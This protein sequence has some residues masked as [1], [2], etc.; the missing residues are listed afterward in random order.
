VCAYL[1]ADLRDPDTILADAAKTLDFSQPVAV[2]LLAVMHFV[3]DDAEATAIIS[4][5]T[6]ACVPGSFV[7][8]SHAASDIDAEQ[9]TEMVRRLNQSVAEKAI[10]RD[11]AGV[12]RLFAGLELVEPGVVRVSDWRPDS[13]FE[14]AS[15]TGLW[16]G[17]GR[18]SR[19]SP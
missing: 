8:I 16:G 12:T 18:K 11:H 10:L 1:D 14:A 13:D 19:Q 4:R 5:L 7:V 17:V 6:A 9:Q 15:P 2:M 3:G